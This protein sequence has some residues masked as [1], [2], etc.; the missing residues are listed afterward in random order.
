MPTLLYHL[1]FLISTACY[2][3]SALSPDT[4]E[5]NDW[6]NEFDTYNVEECGKRVRRNWWSLTDEEQQLYIEGLI[7][8][9]ANGFNGLQS[10]ET[11]EFHL[12]ANVHVDKFGGLVHDS[13]M[14]FWWHSY[15]LW[16]LESRIRNLG[17]PW[18]CFAM[19]FW[20]F[21][22]TDRV[23]EEEHGYI[24]QKSMGGN[25][26]GANWWTVTEDWPWTT[27]QFWVPH[28]CNAEGD[29][30]PLC[31][32]KRSIGHW[33]QLS[34]P[35]TGRI[36]TA[37]PMIVDLQEKFVNYQGM[38]R[39]VQQL[40][41]ESAD[42]QTPTTASY[43]PIWYLFHSMISYQQYMWQDCNDYDMIQ[44]DDLE[45]NHNAYTQFL[46]RDKQ[47]LIDAGI[48]PSMGLDEQMHFAD[49]LQLAEWSFIN[50][51]KLTVR[52]MFHL[53]RWNVIYDLEDGSGF[54]DESGFKDYCA[55]KLNPHWFMLTESPDAEEVEVEEETEQYVDGH[56][57]HSVNPFTAETTFGA[58]VF[59]VVGFAVIA[60]WRSC[61]SAMLK[62]ESLLGGDRVY[63]AIGDF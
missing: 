34:W 25:G 1:T 59:L 54:F 6:S 17:G 36:F 55:D 11:D 57:V 4:A 10:N 53:H 8:L 39:M 48:N 44:P 15:V 12:I 16:E 62:R 14:F 37:N 52:K 46:T 60:L 31:S 3:T 18:K 22:T 42:V 23:H 49:S 5:L 27:E 13:S 35:Q 30:A 51:N 9:R 7:R 58:M 32:F 50:Q 43:D 61:G 38:T 29:V 26:D 24:F 47:D 41:G 2:P 40:F 21:W 45:S 28:H 63:G 20:D 19:P 56:L 33:T